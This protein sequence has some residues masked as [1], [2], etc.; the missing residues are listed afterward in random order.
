[1][2]GERQTTN[3]C[4]KCGNKELVRLGTL[5]CKHCTDCNLSIPWFLDDDQPSLYGGV[6]KEADHAPN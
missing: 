4:P 1:M 2:K 3:Q 5:H 6:L